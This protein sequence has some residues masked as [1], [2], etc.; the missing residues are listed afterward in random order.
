MCTIVHN[1]RRLAKYRFAAD[2]Y[3][4]RFAQLTDVKDV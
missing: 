3:T 1:V 2:A 4:Q